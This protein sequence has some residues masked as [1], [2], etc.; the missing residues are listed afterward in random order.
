MMTIACLGWAS[1][2]WHL[3]ELP[4]H[5]KWFEDGPFLPIEFGRQGASSQIGSK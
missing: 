2:V 3:R 1:L 4:V 5:G